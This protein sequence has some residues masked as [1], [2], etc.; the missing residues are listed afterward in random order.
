MI[1]CWIP[2]GADALEDSA[3]PPP[4]PHILPRQFSNLQKI[5]PP[6]H[7]SSPRHERSAQWLEKCN[8]SCLAGPCLKAKC[9]R[10]AA[11]S[12]YI[13]IAACKAF[14]PSQFFV[15]KE[16]SYL[17]LCSAVQEGNFSWQNLQSLQHL[18]WE[19]KFCEIFCYFWISDAA[20]KVYFILVTSVD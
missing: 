18:L 5:M 12:K 3:P 10:L 1:K 11:V 4:P 7:E 17:S 9:D 13:Y 14:L 16:C 6:S 15:N 8:K 2:Y 20:E 19:A